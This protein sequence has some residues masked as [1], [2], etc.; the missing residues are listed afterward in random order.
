[1]N[2]TISRRKL[3]INSKLAGITTCKSLSQ[4]VGS[5]KSLCGLNISNRILCSSSGEKKKT[6]RPNCSKQWD[7]TGSF[8]S[9]HSHKQDLHMVAASLL[10]LRI[11]GS[12]RLFIQVSNNT[13]NNFIRAKQYLKQFHQSGNWD[14][15]WWKNGQDLPPPRWP[16]GRRRAPATP[17]YKRCPMTGQCSSKPWGGIP[18]RCKQRTSL[19]SPGI[20]ALGHRFEWRLSGSCWS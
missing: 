14:L 5:E 18:P 6:S 11:H 15:T 1:M 19:R 13:W 10:Y 4:S 2:A 17:T 8:Q 7:H 12:L 20:S 3:Q 9:Q 16:W